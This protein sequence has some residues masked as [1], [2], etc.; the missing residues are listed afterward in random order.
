[1]SKS[2]SFIIL[3][4]LVVANTKSTLITASRFSQGYHPD[5]SFSNNPA[6]SLEIVDCSGLTREEC[7]IE[8]LK[9]ALGDYKYYC[10]RGDAN[11]FDNQL[12]LLSF[13]SAFAI[14]INCSEIETV[15]S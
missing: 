6:A 10:P 12:F 15:F 2:L 4:L 9:N 13:M 7:L 11:D 1:M 5:A 3:A 8:K 14:M